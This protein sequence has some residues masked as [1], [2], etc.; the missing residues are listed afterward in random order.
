MTVGDTSA[1]NRSMQQRP[2]KFS[3]SVHTLTAS[4]FGID[5][6]ETRKPKDPPRRLHF[7]RTLL[8]RA[9]FVR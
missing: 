2:F 5:A 8:Q 1:N 9:R 7:H 6:S 4:D 3:R